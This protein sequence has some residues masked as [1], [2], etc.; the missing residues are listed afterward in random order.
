MDD[1]FF[2]LLSDIALTR[3]SNGSL[4]IQVNVLDQVNGRGIL[5][6]KEKHQLLS[7]LCGICACANALVLTRELPHQPLSLESFQTMVQLLR[8]EEHM[9]PVIAQTIDAL[10]SW[11]QEYLSLH[12]GEFL[13]EGIREFFS[14]GLMGCFEIPEMMRA[15]VPSVDYLRFINTKTFDAA[16]LA[17]SEQFEIE[18]MYLSQEQPFL[19]LPED[20]FLQSSDANGELHCSRFQ[21]LT[22]FRPTILDL[23]GHFAVICLLP[24]VA[25][26]GQLI[27]ALVHFESLHDADPLSSSELISLLLEKKQP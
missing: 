17:Q 10:L 5:E 3:L 14:K 18:K 24:F 2:S 1:D 22:P 23:K 11:R 13:D 12:P 4:L 15:V 20:Y 16:L 7:G 26:G 19:S 21:G 25:P 8:D 6:L 27:N 9:L